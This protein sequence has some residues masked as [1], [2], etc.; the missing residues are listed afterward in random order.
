METLNQP[1]FLSNLRLSS[2]KMSP[3][4]NGGDEWPLSTAQLFSRW[5]DFL[6]EFE[7]ELQYHKGSSNITA[8]YL[9]RVVHGDV[10]SDGVDEG[11]LFFF[12]PDDKVRIASTDLELSLLD[13]T[14]NIA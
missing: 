9:S 10:G 5:L 3:C 6:T 14:G 1:M 12:A 11:E 8:E 2:T 4:I 13:V 7:F